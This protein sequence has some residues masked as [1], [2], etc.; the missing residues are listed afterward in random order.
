MAKK[1]NKKQI[2]QAAPVK[3]AAT[4]SQSAVHK[5]NTVIAKEGQGWLSVKMLCVLLGLISFVLY[6]NT[7]LN[8]YVMDDVMVLRDNTM[9]T[10]G[11]KAIP[12][13]LTTP[14]MRGYLVI[15]NDLYRPLS[16]VM[17][18]VEYQFF[19]PNGLAGYHFFNVL[20]FAGCVIMFFLFLDKFFDRKKTAI[21]FVGALIFAVHPI[22]TEVVANI[23]SCDEL[24]CFFFGFMSLNLFVNYMK[25]G[26]M[27]HLVL[28]TFTLFLSYISKE[29]VIAFVAIIPLLFF[30]YINDDKKRAI[31]ITG[32]MAAATVVFLG[33]RSH[34]LSEYNAN[35]P[36]AGVEFIDNALA[37][38]PA[39]FSLMATKIVVLGL[40]LKLMFIPHPLLCT[41]SFNAI[42]FADLA[43]W[44]VWVS[45]LAYG[46][47]IW[48]AVTRFIKNKK[49]PWA[50]SI[51]FYLVTLFLFSNLPFLMG[52][53]LAERFEFFASAGFCLAAAQA[54]EQW[55]IKSDATNILSLKSTKVLAVLVPVSL[56]FGGLTV[57]RNADWKD[58]ITLYKADVANSP[59]DCRL[60]HNVGSALAE[61]V[62]P[63]IKDTVKQKELDNESLEYLRKGLQIFPT[64][65]DIHVEMGRVFDRKRMYDSAEYHDEIALKYNPIN[66]TA[67]NN[68]GSVYLTNGKYP[69]AVA[70]FKRALEL[71]P[72]FKFPYINLARTYVQL[73]QYDSAL[74]NYHK[75]LAFEPNSVEGVQGLGIAF[76]QMQRFDSAEYYFN[77]VLQMSPDNPNALTYLGATLLNEKRYP[78]SIAIFRKSIGINP[79]D[80][81]AYSNM[82]KAFYFSQQYDQAIETISKEISI[83]QRQGVRD[84][85]YI[86]LSYEK[87]GDMANAKK[88]EAMAKQV[89]SNFKLD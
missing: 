50:F 84:L 8:G 35:Q 12:E 63:T 21:A 77:K 4:V 57:A 9:V 32:G 80:L 14:H 86:A 41:Y 31:F 10:Q 81:N 33:I 26:K 1:P 66:F 37:N 59:E 70:M 22:H 39:Q 28:G 73:K 61:D 64:Y 54:V 24:L 82:G 17:L 89:Y 45:V 53:E 7:L 46:G 23:K 3:P 49:D 27:L 75:M 34:V 2:P 72:N 88:Y 56:I 13:L 52:A 68:L 16:L 19:G 58:N 25:G 43:D 60:Y 38:V 30:F 47:M 40:Y 85:P 65:A 74:I 67:T 11:M 69:Q 29:T 76:F 71:N 51:I 87:K 48:F 36:S 79:N 15:P 18:S 6:A 62:Y 55:L 5:T 83:D 20:I 78:Q 44:R 42:H